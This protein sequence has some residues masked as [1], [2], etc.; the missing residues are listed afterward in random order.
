M[1]VYSSVEGGTEIVFW[2]I[3][4]DRCRWRQNSRGP[5]VAFPKLAAQFDQSSRLN[6]I[7]S[8]YNAM[9]SGRYDHEVPLVASVAK[10]FTL[11][12]P[13]LRPLGT[14]HEQLQD[15]NDRLSSTN[16]CHSVPI[17]AHGGP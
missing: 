12:V 4:H 11:H 10:C 7:H 9:I 5:A 8:S 1:Q 6:S 16:P 3:H 2:S 15:C 13:T 17:A 14:V